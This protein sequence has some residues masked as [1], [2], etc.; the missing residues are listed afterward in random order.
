MSLK[1]IVLAAGIA[2]ALASSCFTTEEKEI[3]LNNGYKCSVSSYEDKAFVF[4]KK[5]NSVT[6][7][8]AGW[9]T[10]GGK[11]IGH[12]RLEYWNMTPEEALKLSRECYKKAISL[13]QK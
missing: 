9:I 1:K 10:L 12:E 6:K 8:A 4:V 11:G 5:E 13:Q 7:K 2:S 3:Q